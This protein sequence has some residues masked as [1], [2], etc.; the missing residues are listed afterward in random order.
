MPNSSGNNRIRVLARFKRL[1]PK[2]P[3]PVSTV[4]TDR[5]V[6]SLYDREYGDRILQR[7]LQSKV[8]VTES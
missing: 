8:Q 2:H 4:R 5:R 3:T 7:Q 1:H 6:S